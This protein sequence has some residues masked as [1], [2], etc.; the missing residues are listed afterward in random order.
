MILD[1]PAVLFR[2]GAALPSGAPRTLIVL[3]AARGGTTMV[4]QI[5]HDLGIFMGQGFNSTYQDDAMNQISRALFHGHIDINNPV[6]E[7]VLRQR[8]HRFAIWGWKFPTHVFETIY[9]KARNPHV[10]VVFRDPVA[11]ATRESV[12]QAYNVEP[13]FQ[14]ALEQIANLGRFVS[15]TAYPCLGVSYERGLIRKAEL[16]DELVEFAGITASKDLRQ[17]AAQRAQPGSI[18]YLNDTQASTIE[19]ALDRVDTRIAGWLRYPHQGNRRVV[20]TILID[21]V[22]IYNGKADRFRTDLK[23][24][25]N[26][27]GCCSFEIPTPKRLIDGQKHKIII[28]IPNENDCVI[29]N[30]ETE[31]T[32]IPPLEKR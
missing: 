13:C 20:F 19:G 7:Q 29:T 25:F 24:A 30:N 9:E 2:K 22:P 27:D 21:N 5:L 28:A 12:S 8:D 31:W 11:I 1:D 3:G 4:A 17:H 26:N 32:I 6:I 15:S 16:V 18:Q 23:Q 14:R 10:I